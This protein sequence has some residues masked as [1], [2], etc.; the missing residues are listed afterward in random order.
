MYTRS[1][2][3]VQ[4]NNTFNVRATSD[5]KSAS[6]F[7]NAYTNEKTSPTNPFTVLEP[8]DQ[9]IG[10]FYVAQECRV[11]DFGAPKL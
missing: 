11:T 8:Q 3:S 2:G 7:S 6:E 10:E 5:K 4:N 1:A 9:E